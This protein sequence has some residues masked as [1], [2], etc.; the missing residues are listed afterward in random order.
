[1]NECTARFITPIDFLGCSLGKHNPSFLMIIILPVFIEMSTWFAS[2]YFSSSRRQNPYSAISQVFFV[3]RSGKNPSDIYQTEYGVLPADL[4]PIYM[5][6]TISIHSL[7]HIMVTVR[8]AFYENN[9][10][11]YIVVNTP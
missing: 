4:T 2:K 7:L 6:N 11:N 9:P 1:M 10:P 3:R 5:I 8:E